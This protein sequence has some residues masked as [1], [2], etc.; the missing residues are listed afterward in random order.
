[1][2]YIYSTIV[3]AVVCLASFSDAQDKIFPLSGKDYSF[4]YWENGVRK[5]KGDE[6]KDILCLETGFFGLKLDMA[7]LDKAE[8]GML[9]DGLDYKGALAAGGRM[10]QLKDADLKI[11]LE[12]GGKVYRAVSCLASKER[13]EGKKFEGTMLWESA[14]YVQNFEIQG[15]EFKAADGET[16]LADSSLEVIAW[17]SSLNFTATVSPGV[18]YKDGPEFGVHGKGICVVDAPEVIEHEEGLEN[19]VFTVETWIKVPRSLVNKGRG[20]ILCK[21]RNE[22]NDGNYG[23]ILSNGSVRGVMNIGGK[24]A[25]NVH[26][27][28]TKSKEINPDT[29]YHVAMTYDGTTLSLYLDGNLKK[30]KVI[31]KKRNLGNGALSLGKRADGNGKMA[32]MIMDELRVWN[33]AL[34]RN[35]LIQHRRNAAEIR[36]RKGLTYENNFETNTA[37]PR[38]NWD[39][40]KLSIRFGDARYSKYAEQENSGFWKAGE[41]TSVTL[42]CDLGAKVNPA[43]KVAV[44]MKLNDLPAVTYDK[45]FNCYVARVHNPKRERNKEFN[46]HRDYDEIDIT[47][48]SDGVSAIPFMLELFT[49]ASITGMCPILCDENGVPT[50]LPVQLSKNWHYSEMGDYLRSSMV[51]PTVKGQKKYKLRIVYGFYGTVPSA[52][53]SQLSLVGYGGNGRW[54]QLAIGAWGETYCMDMDMSLVDVAVTDIRMLMARNGKDGKKWQWTDAGWG[55]DWLG[56]DGSTGDKLLFKGMKAAYVAHGPC[57]T[58]V[59]YDGYYGAESEVGVSSTVR[60]LRTNDYARTFTNIKYEFKKRVSAEGWLFKMGR[61]HHLVTPKIAYGN[62]GGLIREHQSSNDLKPKTKFVPKTTLSGSGPWW[63]AF[64]NATV[65]DS[66]D[67]GKGYRAMVIRSYKVKA[68]GKDYSKPVVEFPVYKSNESGANI[69]FLLRA[70]EGVKEFE[71]GDVVELE[72]EWITLPNVADDYYGSND[73][74]RRHVAEN[75]GSWKTTYREALGNDLKVKVDG[76]KLQQSYPIIIQAE[77]DEVAVEIKGGVGFVPVRFEG[78]KSAD[79]YELY[80]IV[81]GKEVKL[82]QSVHGNDFWQTDYDVKTNSFKMTFNLPLDGIDQSKWLLKR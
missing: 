7:Q 68:G 49:P 71:P 32:P 63:V 22:T 43:T 57:M 41:S 19:E 53:H 20:W 26:F 31:G 51:L 25:G 36:N 17:P 64:P 2:K 29:W 35:E 10:Q 30:S 65:N 76:G 55:G 37:V 66:R 74:F 82:D 14:R 45:K 28:D 18:D 47:V 72:V 13:A 73:T 5:H 33:R 11:E 39:D 38:V 21:N 48:E 56:L 75:P 61:S 6:S 23:L 46:E 12:K 60:T 34:S 3:V 58:E 44:E 27:V 40:A 77:K 80:Q 67:W 24:G 69:D 59:A 62:E 52:S 16:L 1:M 81:D 15:V 54:D 42:N 9:N 70:P 79:G 50:G 78:L 8:F 4:G